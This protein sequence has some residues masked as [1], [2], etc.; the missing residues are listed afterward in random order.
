MVFDVAWQIPMK[1]RKLCG[2]EMYSCLPW[3]YSII[4]VMIELT[5]WETLGISEDSDEHE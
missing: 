4:T 1:L 3:K 5:A 2:S